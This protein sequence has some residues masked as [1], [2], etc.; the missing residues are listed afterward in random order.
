MSRTV[1]NLANQN[2]LAQPMFFGDD[3]G[4]ARYDV[5][6]YPI[7]EK[8]TNE[9][10]SFF[11]RPEEI[12]LDKDH[13][14][15]KSLNQAE[16]HIFLSNLKYQIIMDSVNARGPSLALL[17]Y[18]SLP[19]LEECILIWSLME[20]IHSRAYTH[21]IRNIVKDSSEVFD[22]ILDE[23]ALTTRAKSVTRYYDDF[24][25]YSRYYQML[26]VGR[27]TINGKE[28]NINTRKLKQK[29]YMMLVSIYGLESVR[30]Y[31]SFACS[32]SFTEQTPAKMEGNTKE[33]SFI[34]RDENMHTAITLNIIKNYM[35]K[36]NDP[37]MLEV[38][39]DCEPMVYALFQEIVDGEKEWA[40]YLFKYGSI[41]GLNYNI[42][43]AYIEYR[44]GTR[45]NNLGLT[46]HGYNTSVDPLPWMKNYLDNKNKQV[47]PQEVEIPSYLIGGINME[48]DESRLKK[49]KFT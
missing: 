30:F 40:K 39:K 10:L 23:E 18:V 32:F 42:A 22:H 25:E 9:Q 44:A 19:E 1:F 49:F 38:I 21:I 5:Q 2:A 11:W 36:E 48:V 15:F 35:K 4:I 43:C 13:R 17:P 12:K 26:G 33:L 3:L 37:E 6:K 14:D 45:M 27:H 16:K 29:M 7:F 46:K 20:S 24:I 41:M 8:L 47:S 31:F 34:A 28:I